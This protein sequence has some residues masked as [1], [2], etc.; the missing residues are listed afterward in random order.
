[1]R[2]VSPHP[3]KQNFLLLDSFLA[4]CNAALLQRFQAEVLGR[5]RV[6]ADPKGEAKKGGKLKILSQFY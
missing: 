1:L 6:V 5:L 2:S 3:K 4:Y